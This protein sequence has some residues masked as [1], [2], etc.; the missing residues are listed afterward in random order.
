MKASLPFNN[1]NYKIL[2]TLSNVHT[3][4]FG[5]FH[6]HGPTGPLFCGDKEIPLRQKSLEVLWHLACR[7]DKT[8]SKQT[9]LEAVWP[10]LKGSETGLSVCVLEIRRALDDNTHEPNYIKT[11]HGS[12]YRFIAPLTTAHQNPRSPPLFGREQELQQIQQAY[13]KACGGQRQ[14]VLISGEAGIG[15]T[16]LLNAWQQQLPAV[17]EIRL[18][19]GQ[20]VEHI[21]AG[22]E[23]Y[24]PVLEALSDLCYRLQDEDVIVAL[25][26]Y[27]PCW[28]VRMA[29]LIDQ[30]ED[31]ALF[32]QLK[33][34]HP[35]RM[36]R[37]LVDLLE[38]LSRVEPL[39][40]ILEDLQWSDPAT[41]EV[42]ALL[43][44]RTQ[45]ARLLIVVSYQPVEVI[46]HNHPL[47]AVKQELHQHGLCTEIVMHYLSSDA[48]AGYLTQRLPEQEGC[49]KLTQTIYQRTEGHP[50]YMVLLTDYLLQHSGCSNLTIDDS[51]EFFTPDQIDL[52]PASVRQMIE[53]QLNRLTDD[54]QEILEAGSVQGMRFTIAAVAAALE[55][56]SAAVEAICERFH[57]REQFITNNG[58][59]EWPDGTLSGCY[60]FCHRLFPE[61]CYGRISSIR[62]VRLNQRIGEHLEQAFAGQ[63]ADIAP[64]LAKHFEQAQDPE[65]TMRYRS[66]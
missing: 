59:V 2:M 7:G 8:V 6:L 21:S 14:L 38:A 41:I 53:C 54:E 13:V 12:G 56:S 52:L 16:A 47:K 4:A 11:V 66:K 30:R 51:A 43:A 60:Q 32:Q 40:I 46:V 31:E 1:N 62:K 9:L 45:A 58:L 22:E 24:A 19:L 26:R 3:L 29:S 44:R 34:D 63:E 50:L 61:V 10:G 37:E 28:L 20:C 18:G 49:E 48:V 55:K 42:L 36:L 27:A 57:Q 39:V 33:E 15:K 64:E 65:R 5:P 23:L 17:P 35:K 25:R